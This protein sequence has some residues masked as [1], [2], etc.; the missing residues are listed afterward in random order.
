MEAGT[1][2]LL[3]V[4]AEQEGNQEVVAVITLTLVVV[5]DPALEKPWKTSSARMM[6]CNIFGRNTTM[7]MPYLSI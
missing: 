3:G 2:G 1:A 5:E 4:L 6:N 7:D